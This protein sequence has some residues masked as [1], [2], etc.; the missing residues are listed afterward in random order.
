MLA[1]VQEMLRFYPDTKLTFEA[2]RAEGGIDTPVGFAAD[3]SVGH[4]FGEYCLSGLTTGIWDTQGWGAVTPSTGER[5][6]D[7]NEL[8]FWLQYRPSSGPLQGFRVKTQYEDIWQQG[9]SRN[10]QA[11]CRVIVDYTVLFRPALT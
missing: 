1:S 10:P 4:A 2:K 3:Q 9:N 8:D 5:I 6:A 7:G 11:E